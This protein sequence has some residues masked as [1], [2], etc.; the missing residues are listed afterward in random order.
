[1]EINEIHQKMLDENKEK[2]NLTK[3]ELSVL[4]EEETLDVDDEIA[5]KANDLFCIKKTI[6]F[7]KEKLNG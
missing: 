3:L 4:L 5:K 6:E 1:M 2:F 7:L